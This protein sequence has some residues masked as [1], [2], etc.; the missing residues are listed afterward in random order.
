MK[1]LIQ[2]LLAL[3]LATMAS[4]V[5]TQSTAFADHGESFRRSCRVIYEDYYVIEAYCRTRLGREIYNQFD[6]QGC[7]SDISNQNGRLT[8]EKGYAGGLPAGSYLQSC[9][10]CNMSYEGYLE[11]LCRDGRGG[12]RPTS[13][14]VPGC[15]GP[16]DN[17]YGRLTCS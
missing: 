6:R 2:T 9:H 11:C 14:Y 16:I 3:V 7:I 15:R 12:V 10:S 17:T 5:S 4:T 13:I 1:K 8:C